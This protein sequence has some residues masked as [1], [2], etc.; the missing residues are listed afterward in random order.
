MPNTC[1][2][3]IIIGKSLSR[4]AHGASAELFSWLVVGG[5]LMGMADEAEGEV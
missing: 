2:A 4:S 1:F 5:A 3:A